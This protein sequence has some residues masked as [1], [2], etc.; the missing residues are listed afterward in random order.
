MSRVRQ[1][2]VLSDRN[3]P[4]EDELDCVTLKMKIDS[5]TF[6]M[7]IDYAAL[8]MIIVY[9]TLKR[10]IVCT[11]LKMMIIYVALKI[12]IAWPALIEDEDDDRLC[13]TV[14]KIKMMVISTVSH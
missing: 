11:A 7:K 14:L 10:M 1:L 3:Q 2:V 12:V 6:K 4:R 5:A 13:C 9:A 8:K